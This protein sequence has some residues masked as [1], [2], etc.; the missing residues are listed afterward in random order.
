MTTDGDS[1]HEKSKSKSLT[2][3]KSSSNLKNGSSSSKTKIK[4]EPE[5]K[6]DTSKKIKSEPKTNGSS[7]SNGTAVKSESKTPVKQEK[8][9]KKENKTP[10]SKNIKKR[11]AEQTPNAESPKKRRKKEEEEEEVWRWWEEKKYTD[12]RK[13]TT[14]EHK[15]P[16][17]AE[18]Y[19]LLPSNVKF[20]Y[21]NEHVVLCPAA[22]EVHN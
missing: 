6:K 5:I 1:K 11:N 3:G 13:W 15:G 12:G 8:S 14:L 20:Y 10:D 18:E 17:F 2:N 21:N 22:E 9:V 19:E 16:L 4:S 7:K